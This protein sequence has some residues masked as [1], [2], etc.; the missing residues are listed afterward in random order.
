MSSAEFAK[1]MLKVKVIL[2]VI[3]HL[4]LTYILY[5]LYHQH[6]KISRPIEIIF[7]INSPEHKVLKVSYCDGL[8]SI[9]RPSRT[10]ALN[11]FSSKTA[12]QNLK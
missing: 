9:V 10:S 11:D 4:L 1:R 6:L 3:Y 2:K 7:L 8:L 5:I 12:G